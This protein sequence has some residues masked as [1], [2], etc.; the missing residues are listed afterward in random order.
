MYEAYL[1]LKTARER[2]EPWK[3]DTQSAFPWL[4]QSYDDRELFLVGI[5]SPSLWKAVEDLVR[6]ELRVEDRGLNFLPEMER[7]VTGRGFASLPNELKMELVYH[8]D[9]RDLTSLTF[10]CKFYWKEGTRIIDG[11]L[12]RCFIAI[13]LDWDNLRFALR[14]LGGILTGFMVRRMM[15]MESKE[16]RVRD[17]DNIELRVKN[18]E[19][20][21]KWFAAATTYR[22]IKP[23]PSR[24]DGVVLQRPDDPTGF[25]IKLIESDAERDVFWQHSTAAFT[26]LGSDGFVVPYKTLGFDSKTMLCDGIDDRTLRSSIETAHREGLEIVPFHENKIELCGSHVTCPSVIRSTLDDECFAERLPIPIWS[27]RQ[28][29]WHG[30]LVL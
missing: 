11:F 2:L 12:K 29:R 17:F 18:T 7:T 1:R 23:Q 27:Y 22:A 25:R 6:R 26:W 28:R 5:E 20:A 19:M 3:N 13:G 30:A 21:T 4:L 24:F 14:H 16:F 8:V 9:I 15:F 10:S